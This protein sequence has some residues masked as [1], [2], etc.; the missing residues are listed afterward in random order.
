M[1]PASLGGRSRFFR[2]HVPTTA[3]QPL[4]QYVAVMSRVPRTPSSADSTSVGFNPYQKWTGRPPALLVGRGEPLKLVDAT[5]SSLAMSSSAQSLVFVGERGIG[6]TSLLEEAHTLALEAGLACTLLEATPFPNMGAT[7]LATSLGTL[8]RSSTPRTLTRYIRH[9]R[10]FSGDVRVKV[11]PLE[12]AVAREAAPPAQNDQV[13][14][15]AKRLI[16]AGKAAQHRGRGAVVILD[17]LQRYEPAVL[18]GLLFGLHIAATRELPVAMIAAG[19]P[20]LETLIR[21]A[22]TYGDRLV[23]YAHIDTLDQADAADALQQPAHKRNVDFAVDALR[24]LVYAAAGHPFRLQLH[25]YFTW[26]CHAM[27]SGVISLGVA[28]EGCRLAQEYLQR[29]YYEPVLRNLGRREALLVKEL[30]ARPDAPQPRHEVVASA[31]L[32]DPRLQF[33]VV[34]NLLT[35]DR[36]VMKSVVRVSAGDRICLA[37]PGLRAYMRETGWVSS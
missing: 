9:L 27:R 24:M 36:L 1:G 18:Q 29:N 31:H 30:A 23:F 17:E 33:T 19:L 3:T 20:G 13:V 21:D 12:L 35:V 26:Q 6:K 5:V 8:E 14:K 32:R 2:V 25:G 10:P 16:R 28:E 11:P 4:R 15:V 22:L 7:E 37:D 34:E